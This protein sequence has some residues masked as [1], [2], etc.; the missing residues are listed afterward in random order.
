MIVK[1]P[2]PGAKRRQLDSDL[3]YRRPGLRSS[4]FTHNSVQLIKL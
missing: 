4:F 2:P 3:L 1:S